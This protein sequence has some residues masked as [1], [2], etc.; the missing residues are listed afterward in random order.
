MRQ[1]LPSG[2]RESLKPPE[3]LQYHVSGFQAVVVFNYST[4]SPT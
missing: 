3:D 2:V 4:L 1:F